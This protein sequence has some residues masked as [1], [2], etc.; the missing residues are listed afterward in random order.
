MTAKIK[1]NKKINNKINSV[2]ISLIVGLRIIC[3]NPR[4]NM[5]KDESG[6]LEYHV[7]LLWSCSVTFLYLQSNHNIE[8]HITTHL[9]RQHSQNPSELT[10]QTTATVCVW[11][12][13]FVP[14]PC[15]H[16]STRYTNSPLKV[17]Q[18]PFCVRPR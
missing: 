7:K 9:E 15:H 6:N 14:Y 2:K 13:R 11:L 18:S 17:T 4:Y 10:L 1:K 16:L 5:G 8:R 3:L 12:F